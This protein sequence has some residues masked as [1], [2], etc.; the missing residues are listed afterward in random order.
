M[1][2]HDPS[3]YLTNKHDIGWDPSVNKAL[4]SY[5]SLCQ[6]GATIEQ[7][8]EKI[9]LLQSQYGHQNV[10]FVSL[11]PSQ[12]T[13]FREKRIV[14][15]MTDQDS[16]YSPA[17]RTMRVSENAAVRLCAHPEL[18]FRPVC[19]VDTKSLLNRDNFW[20]DRVTAYSSIA[21]FAYSGSTDIQSNI[22]LTLE[23][24]E[25]YKGPCSF[26]QIT[27]EEHD[28]LLRNENTR[29]RFE[30]LTASEVYYRPPPPGMGI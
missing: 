3:Q 2:A 29:S 17:M 1:L 24:S 15:D 6:D 26:V 19:S 27:P 28:E 9:K 11:S 12:A 22:D 21:D 25:R 4:T 10:D 30:V 7:L 5:H 8:D 20:H 13:D 14:V 18:G 23:G 16:I